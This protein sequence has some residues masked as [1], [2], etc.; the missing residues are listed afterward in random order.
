MLR[1][2]DADVALMADVLAP[3]GFEVT[4]ATGPRATRR[5]LIEAYRALIDATGAGDAAVVYYSGHGGQARDPRPAPAPGQPARIQYLCPTDIDEPG[6]PGAFP[7]L[8][9]DELSLLQDELSARTANVTTIIDSCH[10]ARMARTARQV[11]KARTEGRDWATVHAAWRTAVGAAPRRAGRPAAE[12]NPS[13]VRLVACEPDAS[14]YEVQ[15]PGFDGPRGLL[16]ASL[17]RLLRAPGAHRLTWRTLLGLLRPAVLDVVPFQRPEVEGPADRL[18]FDTAE[19]RATGVLPVSADRYGAYLDGAEL[20]GVAVGDQYALVPPG[21]DPRRPLATAVVD[22]AEAG[23]A[24]LRLQGGAAHEPPPEIPPPGTEAHPLHVSLGRRP[25]LLHPADHPDHARVAARLRACAHLRIARSDEPALAVV[26]LT[27]DG[28]RLA[29][30]DGEPLRAA[31]S[32]ATDTGL[33]SLTQDLQQLARAAHVRALA[34]GTGPAAL[35]DD[36]T[37]HYALLCADGTQQPLDRSGAHVFHGDEIVV[38]LHNRAAERRHVSVFDV[39]LRG[40]VTQL[41]T[42]EPAGV[43]LAPDARYELFRLPGS[44]RLAG[45]ELYWPDGLPRGVP[46]P[47]TLVAVVTDRPQDL[48]RLAQR[49]IARRGPGGSALQRLVDDVVTGVRDARAPG[50]AEPPVRYR[51]ARCDVLLHHGRRSGPPDHAPHA[52]R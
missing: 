9:A 27:P 50:A 43:G 44:H 23:T 37:F 35:P 15:L 47:E 42:T 28:L 34:S 6:T 14:A 30:A 3:L 36:V 17:A 7:G 13:V 39:G 10:S 31:A 2:V 38:H 16:T 21:G 45:I 8:F 24:R 12:S 40:A 25:V 5:G 1:G 19:Q 20:F 33:D 52:G 32:P 48:T 18:L 51:V 29:D 11:P 4:R 46:R 41:T 22:R 26:G 49:G